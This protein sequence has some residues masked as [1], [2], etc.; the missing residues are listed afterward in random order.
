MRPGRMTPQARRRISTSARRRYAPRRS[1]LP[2]PAWSAP[3]AAA[4]HIEP[5]VAIESALR[6]PWKKCSSPKKYSG[7]RIASHT[8]RVRA[9]DRAGNVDA[10]PAAKSFRIR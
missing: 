1:A 4:S 9:V 8:I 6:G 7:L 5:R 10:T 2:C 3:T